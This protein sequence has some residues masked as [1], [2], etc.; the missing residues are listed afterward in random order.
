MLIANARTDI[1]TQWKYRRRCQDDQKGTFY[2]LRRIPVR[3][4]S[5]PLL[6]ARVYARY[7]RITQYADAAGASVCRG[8]NCTRFSFFFHIAYITACNSPQG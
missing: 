8:I 2:P 6:L 1:R 5:R 7:Y 3:V 4:P